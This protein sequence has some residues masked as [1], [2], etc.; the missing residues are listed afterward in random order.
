MTDILIKYGLQWLLSYMLPGASGVL[1]PHWYFQSSW[2]GAVLKMA[3]N[4]SPL[5]WPMHEVEKD[6]V[7]LWLWLKIKY[8]SAATLY[9]LSI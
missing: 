7:D 3:V 6:G 9:P 4:N 8:E 2:L 1:P 5:R